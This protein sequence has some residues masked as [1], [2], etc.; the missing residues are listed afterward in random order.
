[1][2]A[3]WAGQVLT[4]CG[5]EP[6]EHAAVLGPVKAE[7]LWSP[8]RRGQSPPSRGLALD[9]PCARRLRDLAVGTEECSRRGSNQRM[10]PERRM[11]SRI[12]IRKYPALSQTGMSVSL[13]R[14]LTAREAGGNTVLLSGAM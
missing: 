10:G 2:H 1:M 11:R 4:G 8:R 13:E 14:L 5:P 3:L 7:P 6:I 12:R 9:R